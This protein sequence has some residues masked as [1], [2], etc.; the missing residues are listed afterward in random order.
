MIQKR[1]DFTLPEIISFLVERGHEVSSPLNV[2]FIGE[3]CIV[4][5][6]VG[7][8]IV[9]RDANNNIKVEESCQKSSITRNTAGT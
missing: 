3:T 4:E 8:V 9:S 7:H 2:R 5:K 6:R 1:L